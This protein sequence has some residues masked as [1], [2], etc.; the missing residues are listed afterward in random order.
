MEQ[1]ATDAKV[2]V[3]R[4]TYLLIPSM[5]CGKLVARQSSKAGLQWVLYSVLRPKPVSE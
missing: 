4:L 3:L 5:R 1:R 2:L